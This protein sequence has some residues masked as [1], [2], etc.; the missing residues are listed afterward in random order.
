M[1]TTTST[2][3]AAT[4]SM[5]YLP[6]TAG[7]IPKPK[8][9]PSSSPSAPSSPSSPN[10][11]VTVSALRSL[12]A[13]AAKAFLLKDITLTHSLL[14]S[15]FAMLPPPVLVASKPDKLDSHRKKWDILR[16]SLESTAHA[17]PV[18]QP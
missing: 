17:A 4:A 13:R 5:S 18:A 1:P 12:Y 3:V 9:A 8:H 6:L 16:I 10:A 15:A 11:T 2:T 7:P 14:T